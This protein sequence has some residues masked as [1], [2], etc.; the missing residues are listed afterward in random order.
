M[1]N[2]QEKAITFLSP[3]E[4]RKTEKISAFL[5]FLKDRQ[6]LGNIVNSFVVS[7][8]TAQKKPVGNYLKFIWQGMQKNN[9]QNLYSQEILWRTFCGEHHKKFSATFFYSKITSYYKG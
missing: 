6:N 9:E 3:G 8:F 1:N 4:Q 5:R 7:T 2:T